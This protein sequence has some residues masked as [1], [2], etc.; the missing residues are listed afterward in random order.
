MIVFRTCFGC[1]SL[2]AG[3]ILIGSIELFA[4]FLTAISH[5]FSQYVFYEA[6]LVAVF[7][8][9]VFDRNC[10]FLWTAMFAYIAKM[11]LVAAAALFYIIFKL[12]Q[13]QDV[14]EK[15]ISGGYIFI[16]AFFGITFMAISSLVIYSYI[17]ELR[18]E[19]ERKIKDNVNFRADASTLDSNHTQ[20]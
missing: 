18:E 7:F 4:L 13:V 2:R 20:V 19:E 5:G 16:A 6:M 17:C 10:L 8:Y 3:C 12:M 1:C 15:E 11:V 9:G 14:D